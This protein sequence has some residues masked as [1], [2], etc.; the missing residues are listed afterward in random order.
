MLEVADDGALAAEDGG[1][2][3]EEGVEEAEV[4]RG[5][6]QPP[7]QRRLGDLDGLRGARRRVHAHPRA[8]P[9]ATPLQAVDVDG[10]AAGSA[11]W[12]SGASSRRE[13]GAAVVGAIR[14]GGAGGRDEEAVLEVALVHGERG[15]GQAYAAG[16]GR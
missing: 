7:H 15:Q 8:P 14:R 3:D 10:H 16:L 6:V 4:P 11:T 1:R 5:Q 9:A 13:R 2:V 12:A